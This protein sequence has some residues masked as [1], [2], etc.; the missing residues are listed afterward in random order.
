MSVVARLALHLTDSL[1]TVKCG[2]RSIDL[3]QLKSTSQILKLK[4]N[5]GKGRN[6][7]KKV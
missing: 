5:A 3:N 2:M 7:C 1:C 6:N 4:E